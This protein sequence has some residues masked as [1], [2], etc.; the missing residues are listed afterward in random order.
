MPV[1]EKLL[2]EKLQQISNKY[3]PEALVEK[4]KFVA[5]TFES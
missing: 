3:E 1:K 4:I 5:A 2:L